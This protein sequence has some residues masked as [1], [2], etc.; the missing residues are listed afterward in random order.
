M[1]TLP[2]PIA[3]VTE[4][5]LPRR[6]SELESCQ[7]AEAAREELW[8]QASFM[9]DLFEGR[10]R[11]DLIHPPPEPDPEETERASIFLQKLR[12]CTRDCIDGD[13]IDREEWLREEV[14]DGLRELGAFGIKIP[15][16]YGGLGLSQVTYN[17]AL[18]IVAAAC[19]STG[20]FLSA[21]QSIGVPQPLTLF[22]TEEQKKRYLPRVAKGALSA[23]ALTESGVG[24]DP[25][26]MSTHA[27][28]REDSAA[29]ILRGEKIWCTN[30]PRAEVMVVMARTLHG[31]TSAPA[32]RSPPSSSRRIGKA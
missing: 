7:V 25:A 2:K 28:P 4:A 12:E 22:G 13:A 10:F 20:A 16:E 1:D 17:R 15:R 6:T 30:G 8:E 5:A 18:G 24:S 11:L 32:D 19:E 29:W 26:N 31:M 14:L 9:R 3:I 21:H 23:F 27:E